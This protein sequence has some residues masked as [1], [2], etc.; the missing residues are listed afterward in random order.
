MKVSLLQLYGFALIGVLLM[1][2]GVFSLNH[3]AP[4]SQ[5][6]SLSS[7][8]QNYYNACVRGQETDP[9]YYVGGSKA[10]MT[11]FNVRRIARKCENALKQY[12]IRQCGGNRYL[13]KE[14]FD[15]LG[16]AWTSKCPRPV[17]E[18]DQCQRQA[19]PYRGNSMQLK[20]CVDL[21]G[22]VK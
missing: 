20:C 1:V 7:P 8:L 5:T 15:K 4:A 12:T 6:A 22:S 16:T 18:C 14:E 2:G 11:V 10:Y 17:K 21:V 9:A 19:I 3:L 13:T